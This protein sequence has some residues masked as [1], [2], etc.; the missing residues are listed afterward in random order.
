MYEYGQKLIVTTDI[1][2]KDEHSNQ[3]SL[4]KGEVLSFVDSYEEDTDREEWKLAPFN[5]EYNTFFLPSIIGKQHIKDYLEHYQEQF[6]HLNPDHVY[7][8]QIQ[9]ISKF[10]MIENGEKVLYEK[11][12]DYVT[13]EGITYNAVRM[14]TFS[15]D[16][17]WIMDN[18]S[19]YEDKTFHYFKQDQKTDNNKGWDTVELP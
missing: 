10:V 16:H 2:Y 9:E 17:Y 11:I 1:D 6:S 7:F 3:I 4:K 8:G 19:T 12:G 13:K 18:I 14:P 15:S 5:D